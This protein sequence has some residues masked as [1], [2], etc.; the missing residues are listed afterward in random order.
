MADEKKYIRAIMGECRAALVPGRAAA[1]AKAIQ[2][3]LLACDEYRAASA[4]VV[5]SAI[6]NEVSTNA[7][8]ADAL[9]AGRPVFFPRVDRSTDAIV[10]R[11][12][13]RAEE[14]EPGAFGILEPPESAE[15]LD[16]A[17]FEKLLVCVPGVAFSAAGER[18]GRGGGH[19][20]R[21]LA[22]LGPDAIAVG[23]AYSFQIL[24]RLPQ[25]D[26]DRQLNFIVTESA[27]HRACEAQSPARPARTEEVQP[28]GTNHLNRRNSARADR[29]R[30]NR[31]LSG[32]IEAGRGR[33]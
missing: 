21:L 25:S 7:I 22:Q 13:S 28:G 31:F 14:L 10:A 29:G 5:Y 30:R 16:P 1:M 27:T 18:I 33:S 12:V 2:R 23:L 26:T 9:A 17:R 3:R 4:I 15:P 8:L 19:Y 32:E 11:R 20:D 6:G 24:D